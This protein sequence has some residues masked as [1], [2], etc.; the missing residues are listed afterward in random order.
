MIIR[1]RCGSGLGDSIYLQSVVRYLVGQGK[2]VVA[3]SNWPDVFRPLR[4]RA[5]V[6]PFDRRNCNLV[7]H[8]SMRRLR[9]TTQFQD[10]YHQAGIKEPV[11][12]RLDWSVT[13][14]GFIEN[15][16]APIIATSKPIILVQ[17]PRRPMDR[18]D[19]FGMN[20]L[21]RR[22]AMQSVINGL[23][24]RA[25][26]VMVGAGEQVY[27]LEGIDLDLTNKTTVAQLIDLGYIADAYLGYVS[28]MVPLAE[29]LDKPFLAVWSRRGLEDRMEVVRSITPKK[30]F[31]KPATSKA[32]FDDVKPA[33]WEAAADA[34]YQSATASR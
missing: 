32:V 10:C 6:E 22:V 13:D 26:I 15:L 16:N 28:F 29:S 5:T 31:H 3:L 9:S 12:L 14:P 8:Y 18:V 1:T 21:P 20:L 23:R 30:I 11:D 25:F 34:I 7:A 24:G 2:E 27:Q 17:M 33:E 4:G 19:G